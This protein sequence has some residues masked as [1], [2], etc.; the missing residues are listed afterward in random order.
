MIHALSSSPTPMPL[1]TVPG[2]MPLE[3]AAGALPLNAP[4]GDSAETRQAFDQ[5]V[6]ESLFGQM[7]KAMRKTQHKAAYFN[8]G[9]AEEIFQQQLDQV[10]VEK[11]SRTSGDKLS[12]GMYQLSNLSRR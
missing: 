3:P 7:L 11:L 1:S 2:A 12:K 8:G 5:F 4:R 10:L 6:G 9:R